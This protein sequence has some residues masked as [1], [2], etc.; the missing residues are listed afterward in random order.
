MFGLDIFEIFV[1]NVDFE[2]TNNIVCAFVVGN[3]G[4]FISIGS[5]NYGYIELWTVQHSYGHVY[6]QNSKVA[7][8]PAPLKNK[9]PSMQVSFV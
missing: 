9:N 8:F 2:H 4:A 7:N 6:L 5:S 3:Q 1:S